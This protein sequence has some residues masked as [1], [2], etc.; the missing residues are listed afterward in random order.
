M[1][2][3]AC[4]FRGQ[5]LKFSETSFQLQAAPGLLCVKLTSCNTVT[6]TAHEAQLGFWEITIFFKL[7]QELYPV[8]VMAIFGLKFLGCVKRMP[9]MRYVF[10]VSIKES[11]LLHKTDFSQ[12]PRILQ[13]NLNR[14]FW[15]QTFEVELKSCASIWVTGGVFHWGSKLAAAWSSP[16][17][18][19]QDVHKTHPISLFNGQDCEVYFH[20]QQISPL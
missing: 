2:A 4:S 14:R 9:N 16:N 1:W 6:V 18:E 12:N 11:G 10:N 8:D 15:S 5:L 17:P 7:Y 19:W 13:H 3:S 20:L